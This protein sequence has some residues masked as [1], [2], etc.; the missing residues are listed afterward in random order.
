M[1]DV[2]IQCAG[3]LLKEQAAKRQDKSLRQRKLREIE[4]V[5]GTDKSNFK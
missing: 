5:E 3:S 4:I 1:Q 2:N